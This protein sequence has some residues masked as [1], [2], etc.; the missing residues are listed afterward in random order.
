[1]KRSRSATEKHR[2]QV[3][4]TTIAVDWRPTLD[5]LRSD[6]IVNATPIG[7]MGGAEVNDLPF[8]R[9]FTAET[10]RIGSRV[11]ISRKL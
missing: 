11:K 1:V 6:L 9:E 7:M 4:A 2:R 5:E 3:L 8:A 10:S